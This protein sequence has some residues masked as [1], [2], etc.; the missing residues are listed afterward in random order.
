M[1]KTFLLLLTLST[2]MF[3]IACGNGSGNGNDNGST[4]YATYQEACR[5]NDFEAAWDIV[6]KL[7]DKAFEV[8]EEGFYNDNNIKEYTSARDKV[9]NSEVQFLMA[10]GSAEASD[11]IL[12][13]LNS[14]PMKGKRL[15]EG[16][17]DTDAGMD[18][19]VKAYACDFAWYCE[20]VNSYNSKCKA[21]ME[22]CI[23]RNN[24]YLADKIVLLVKETPTSES[25]YP[26]HIVHYLDTDKQ[27]V[28][29]MYN[30]ALSNG[31]LK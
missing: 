20:S 6:G 19:R 2:M 13:L 9:F 31:L 18:L 11:R 24:K 26:C 7:E 1:K 15:N 14:L 16:Y 12:F 4:S 25:D 30:E 29:E 10:I 21:I 27:I 17:R 3:V 5:A 22:L 23:S 28:S 8:D